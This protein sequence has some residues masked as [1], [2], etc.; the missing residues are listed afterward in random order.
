MRRRGYLRARRSLRTEGTLALYCREV[1]LPKYIH[2]YDK[3]TIAEK[4]WCNCRKA[5][6]KRNMQHNRTSETKEKQEK[7]K[8]RL[9]T[10]GSESDD[11]RRQQHPLQAKKQN[12][13]MQSKEAFLLSPAGG[14]KGTPL[15]LSKNRAIAGGLC[16]T[17][18]TTVTS[19]SLAPAVE[20]PSPAAPSS[21]PAP[22]PPPPP[23]PLTV[24]AGAPPSDTGGCALA[25]TRSTWK[26]QGGR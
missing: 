23:L 24:A 12:R 22:P 16:A 19:P 14:G 21:P 4:M 15:T 3:M 18:R 10:H 5:T 2:T 7:K 11:P 20:P 17:S 8:K 6:E 9:V 25:L 1:P 26:R 13:P